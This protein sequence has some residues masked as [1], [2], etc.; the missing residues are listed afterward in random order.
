VRQTENQRETNRELKRD[1]EKKGKDGSRETDKAKLVFV[2]IF[3]LLG[4]QCQLPPLPY[5]LERVAATVIDGF[6]VFCGGVDN[7]R[8]NCFK[9]EKSTK[10]WVQVSA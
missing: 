6:P 8:N 5:V 10:T 4:E 1:K 2:T 7:Q 9:L 3:I